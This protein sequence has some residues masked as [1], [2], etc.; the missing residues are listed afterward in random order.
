MKKVPAPFPERRLCALLLA[1]WLGAVCG[2]SADDALALLPERGA[3][4]LLRGASRPKGEVFAVEG[5][6]ADDRLLPAAF[7]DPPLQTRPGCFW[8]WLNGSITAE[9]ITRDLEAMKQGGMRG[10]EIWDVAAHA[11]PDRRVPAGPAFLGPEST[12]LIVHAIREADRLGLELGLVASSGWNAGG[13]LDHA[14]TRRQR[15]LSINNRIDG[16]NEVS[17]CTPLARV[18]ETLSTG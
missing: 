11:D 14:R 8:A 16:A 18:A 6:K 4:L 13:S 9:Q 2:A 10:G 12:R 5:N 17:R 1:A 3:A 7:A 15:A